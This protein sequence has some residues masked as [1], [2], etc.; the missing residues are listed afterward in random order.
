MVFLP[1]EFEK[2]CRFEYQVKGP[3]V[4]NGTH[5]ILRKNRHYMREV[6]AYQ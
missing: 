2:A 5:K 4:E 6:L 3:I 1:Q